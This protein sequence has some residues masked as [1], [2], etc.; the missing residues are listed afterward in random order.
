MELTDF[1]VNDDLSVNGTWVPVGKDAKLLIARINNEKYRDFI[2]KKTKPY[3][4]AIRAGQLDETLMTEIVVEALARTILLG[5][6][7]LT[8]KGEALVYSV[9]KAEDLLRRKEQFRDLVTS[10]ANDASLFQ[11]AEVEDSEKN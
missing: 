8:E 10:L 2:K 1:D 6:E 11:E 9:S 4:S 5:W 3:R 7:G